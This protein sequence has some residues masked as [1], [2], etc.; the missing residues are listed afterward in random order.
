[1]KDVHLLQRLLTDCQ[2]SDREIEAFAEMRDYVSQDSA[3]ALSKKQRDWAK[4]VYDRHNPVYENLVSSGK[5]P[6]RSSVPTPEVLKNLPLR[7][8]G[9][10]A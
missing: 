4:A 3:R 9:R 10:S 6:N 5:V 7:P 8:P 2:L 1:M